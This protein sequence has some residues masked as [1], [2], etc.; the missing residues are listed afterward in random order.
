M[1][2]HNQPAHPSSIE[3]FQMAEHHFALTA[4]EAV[5]TQLET[6]YR[7]KSCWS[8]ALPWNVGLWEG[9]LTDWGSLNQSECRDCRIVRANLRTRCCQIIISNGCLGNTLYQ[10]PITM[11]YCRENMA[12]L[13]LRRMPFLKYSWN[14]RSLNF[15]EIV[16]L[17]FVW[18]DQ[19]WGGPTGIDKNT[20][21][22]WHHRGLH[23]WRWKWM[24]RQQYN[25]AHGEE[26]SKSL[27]I[28]LLKMT[29]AL[30]FGVGLDYEC[31]LAC[32]QRGLYTYAPSL[33]VAHPDSMAFSHL[34]VHGYIE[35]VWNSGT[36]D[37]GRCP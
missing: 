7:L 13:S 22:W 34:G 17:V 33:F 2:R 9:K 19:N 10:R 29:Q 37:D 26:K 35:V 12:T 23:R 27:N 31:R 6:A 3:C 14:I 18:T 20:R 5:I 30:L 16:R 36:E 4:K 21:C 25:S 1:C 32:G 8:F 11:E 24:V 28:S 15:V